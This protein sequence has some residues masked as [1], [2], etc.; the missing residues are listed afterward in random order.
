LALECEA[1][2]VHALHLAIRLG[3]LT[4]ASPDVVANLA[5]RLKASTQNAERKVYKVMDGLTFAGDN[6]GT[7]EFF[8][9]VDIKSIDADDQAAILHSA[10]VAYS[11]S[12]N[13]DQ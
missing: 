10:A 7:I 1:D 6:L 11:N 4:F 13:T 8:G 12:G 5:D 3:R 9:Q 2:N